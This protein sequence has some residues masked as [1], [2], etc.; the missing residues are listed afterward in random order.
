MHDIWTEVTSRTVVETDEEGN[1]IERQQ[2]VLLIH[3][4]IKSTDEMADQY[5]FDDEQRSM[6]D[7]MLK[8]YRSQLNSIVDNSP[9]REH[10][11]DAELSELSN[12]L[13]VDERGAEV[14]RL[15]LTRLGH[16]YNGSGAG[17]S[18]DCSLL[19]QWCYSQVGIALPRTAADQGQYCANNVWE[20]S[21][22]EL[23]PGDFIFFSL[24]QNGRYMNISHVAVYAGDGMMVDASSGKG[25]VVYRKVFKNGVVS[26]A[27]PQEKKG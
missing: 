21:R 11:S 9:A 27:R 26:Y 5:A 4:S 16:P 18:V 17:N 25:K 19:T 7:E 10:L 13:P 24:K 20:V 8:D 12:S 2:L 22:A 14:V 6:L 23:R 1:E 15:A 3:I